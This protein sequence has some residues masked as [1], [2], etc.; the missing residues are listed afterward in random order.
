MLRQGVNLALVSVS[1]TISRGVTHN[2]LSNSRSRLDDRFNKLDFNVKKTG[3]VF[4]NEVL[5]VFSHIKSSNDAS[6]THSL[7]LL[8]CCGSLLVDEQPAKRDQLVDEIWSTLKSRIDVKL[9]ISHFNALLKVHVENGRDL[10]P[11]SFL[12]EVEAAGLEPN[13]VTFQRLI[14]CYCIKGDIEG[15]TKI[16]EF[17][18]SKDVPINEGVFNSLIIGYT[19]IGDFNAAF[20]TIEIMKKSEV[21]PSSVTYTT[22]LTCLAEKVTTDATVDKHFQE[23]FA[24]ANET[25]YLSDRMKMDILKALLVHAPASPHIQTVESTLQKTLGFKTD[26]SNAAT[27]LLH[28]GHLDA[29]LRI[30]YMLPRG[31]MPDQYKVSGSFFV[32]QM[33]RSNFPPEK[34]FEICSR[35]K[36]EGINDFAFQT[37]ADVAAEVSDLKTA[38]MFVRRFL[39]EAEDP[40]PRTHYFWP[41]LVKS[42]N[43]QEIL[44][45]MREDMQS[46]C[47]SSSAQALIDT[48]TDYIWPKASDPDLLM[49]ECRVLG[50]SAPILVSSYIEHLINNGEYSR[51]IAFLRDTKSQNQR[52]IQGSVFKALAVNAAKSGNGGEIVALMKEFHLRNTE[53]DVE[54]RTGQFLVDFVG[55]GGNTRQSGD[56]NVLDIILRRMADQN[57]VVSER[58]RERLSGMNLTDR[59]LQIIKSLSGHYRV[60]PTTNLSGDDFL[61]NG[62]DELEDHLRELQSKNMNTRGCIRK[63]IL[64]YCKRTGAQMAVFM[65]NEADSDA[66]EN[67]E[68]ESTPEKFPHYVKRVKQLVDI[69]RSDNMSYSDGMKSALFEFFATC[70]ELDSAF[71]VRAELSPNFILDDF[72]V[73]NVARFCIREGKV[74]EA[75]TLLRDELEKPG[76]ADHRKGFENENMRTRFVPHEANIFRC[77]NEAAEKTKDPAVVDEILNLCLQFRECKP[78][79]VMLGPKIKVHLL[80][81]DLDSAVEEFASIT[82]LYRQTPWMGELMARLIAQD[83][84]ARLQMITDLAIAIH[85]EPNVLGDLAFAFLKAGKPNQAAKVFSTVG[86]RGNMWKIRAHAERMIR[87]KDVDSL[88][89]LVTVTKDVP[90]VDRDEVFQYLIRGFIAVNDPKKALNVWTLMQEEEVVAS[91]QTLAL[92][93]SFLK[94]SGVEVPFSVPSVPRQPAIRSRN[95]KRSDYESMIMTEVIREEDPIKAYKRRNQLLSEGKLL[96]LTQECILMDKLL[97]DGHVEEAYNIADQLTK[98]GKYPNPRTFRSLFNSL[99]KEGRVDLIEKLQPRLPAEFVN[100]GSYTNALADAYLQAG[101]EETFLRNI[102]PTLKPVPLFSIRAIM[103]KKPNLEGEVIAMAKKYAE[104]EN[105]CLPQNMVWIHY[106]TEKRYDEAS[107]LLQSTPRL[108]NQIM[109]TSVLNEIKDNQDIELADQLMSQLQKTNLSPR[110]LGIVVSAKIDALVDKGKPEE[111]ENV[112]LDLINNPIERRNETTGES[113]PGVQL[114]DINRTALLRLY[115]TVTET[116]GREPKFTIPDKSSFQKRDPETEADK[117]SLDV[118]VQ[119]ILAN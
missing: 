18:K 27:E 60:S 12:K 50:Y 7:L 63:L 74:D 119:S 35:F 87:N 77:V 37:V 86:L 58:Y 102:L 67:A 72:K 85:G 71:A 70:G 109:Y 32:A 97:T 48:F 99:G 105:Y 57:F 8:R 113:I 114:T 117:A 25:V 28:R 73:M 38:R 13:R 23:T 17:M 100:Q 41:L 16:L 108:R 107:V 40:V 79:N 36:N 68:L 84:T 94:E 6:P 98:E 83:D 91:E 101:Q 3:R 82:S 80:K 14:Q 29:A 20:N 52:L 64:E 78:T 56:K 76:R 24:T 2:S 115:H 49:Q 43:Q 75:I 95:D 15:A 92:L 22:L 65:R 104:E 26:A 66:D 112:L 1:R 33:V 42:K 96:S 62:I 55:N 103:Q 11:L 30:F 90:S 21:E 89:K 5:D 4:K 54:D 45:V 44:E 39:Q 118:D 93:G 61:P 116:C 31:G 34:I 51:A 69:L 53:N 110:S 46:V 9:D 19:K 111:A 59:Q 88:E 10:D 47:F 81:N 106:M